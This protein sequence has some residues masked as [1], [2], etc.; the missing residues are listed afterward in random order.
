[1]LKAANYEVSG[2][3]GDGA[4]FYWS[5]AIVSGEC[6]RDAFGNDLSS[7]IGD[8]APAIRLLYNTMME[9]RRRV[10]ERMKD[11][12]FHNSKLFT[13]LQFWEVMPEP[14]NRAA[15]K[16]KEPRPLPQRFKTD[17]AELHLAEDHYT[18]DAHIAAAAIEFNVD[19]IVI[20]IK[21][22]QKDTQNDTC[23]VYSCDGTRQ[24]VNE[25]V[26]FQN[27][28]L[29]RLQNPVPGMPLRM[30]R[31]NG[32]ADAGGH[33]EPIVPIRVETKG[34]GLDGK[35]PSDAAMEDKTHHMQS[36]R[37]W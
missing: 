3:P 32:R 15:R 29:P 10:V 22:S 11:A 2:A 34:G 4:C 12:A 25:V 8:D 19:Y 6:D 27:D 28:V 21:G 14:R 1:M 24:M 7:P 9:K 33:F 37:R 30:I 35:T 26:S 13:L 17:V 36:Y 23:L 5:D 18:A 16:A 31:W 20:T